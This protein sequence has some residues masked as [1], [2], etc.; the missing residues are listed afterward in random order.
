[1]SPE[2]LIDG[3]AYISK[4]F[5]SVRNLFYRFSGIKPWHRSLIGHNICFAI[6]RI[7]S[8]RYRK[9]YEAA[10]YTV[11]QLPEKDDYQDIRNFPEKYDSVRAG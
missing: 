7:N 1:M 2:Q 9:I 11:P 8:Y 4:E 10:K 3:L 6:N 5:N